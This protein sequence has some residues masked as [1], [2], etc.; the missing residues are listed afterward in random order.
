[1][2]VL[3]LVCLIRIVFYLL[4]LCFFGNV[5]ASGE[6][7]RW[8]S[9]E[10]RRQ[11]TEYNTQNHCESEAADAGTAK[12]E[13]NCKYDERRYR[14]VDSTVQSAVQRGVEQILLVA[15][16]IQLE[17]FTNTVEYNHLVVDRITNSSQHRT[18]ECLVNLKRER[19]PAPAHT[20]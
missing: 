7:C 17:E 1:M 3:R 13:D 18:N 15:L 6:K 19:H 14:S 12:A 20:P 4:L 9:N 11:C 10:D 8:S 5:L 2:E 16:R